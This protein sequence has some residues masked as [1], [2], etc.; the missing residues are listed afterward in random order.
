M[1]KLQLFLGLILA[2][3]AFVGVLLFGQATQPPVYDVAVVVKE[4]PAFTTLSADL[5]ATDSQSV[6]SAVAVESPA[7]TGASNMAMPCLA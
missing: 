4:I 2:I 5:F 6:S 3:G 1:R 7:A